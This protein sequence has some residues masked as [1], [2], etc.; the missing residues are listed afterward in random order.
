M[1]ASEKTLRSPGKLQ[2]P[3]GKRIV[4]NYFA[5]VMVAVGVVVAIMIIK[6]LGRAVSNSRELAEDSDGHEVFAGPSKEAAQVVHTLADAG[7]I[8][9]TEASANGETK[10]FVEENQKDQVPALLAVQ[11]QILA[12]QA[13]NQDNPAVSAPAV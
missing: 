8:G 10:V 5:L 4:M 2:S 3:G 11:Q 7:I 1:A 6:K 13:E 12:E 9:W